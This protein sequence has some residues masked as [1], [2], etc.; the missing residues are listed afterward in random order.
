MKNALYISYPYPVRQRETRKERIEA[1][2]EG[3]YNLVSVQNERGE[4]VPPFTLR[5][6]EKVQGLLFV[7]R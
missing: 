3:Y 2:E 5:K 6:G 4:L 7:K 1:N